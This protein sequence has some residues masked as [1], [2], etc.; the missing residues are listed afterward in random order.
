MASSKPFL[1]GFEVLGDGERCVGHLVEQFLFGEVFQ[2][3]GFVAL[4]EPARAPCGSCRLRPWW[5]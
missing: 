5:R 2:P 3:E 4:V 1:F